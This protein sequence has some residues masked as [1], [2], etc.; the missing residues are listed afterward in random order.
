MPSVRGDIEHRRLN[1]MHSQILRRP[2][3]PIDSPLIFASTSLITRN[4]TVQLVR[5]RHDKGSNNDCSLLI[6]ERLMLPSVC[7]LEVTVGENP[8]PEWL[9]HR[10]T[11]DRARGARV[12][13]GTI[14]KL[15]PRGRFF[16]HLAWLSGGLFVGQIL[17]LAVT[18]LLSRLYS[19]ADFGAFAV[20]AALNGIFGL[21]MAGRYEYAIPLA[22]EENE[23]GAL[24]ALSTIFTALLALLSCLLVWMFAK[25][26]AELVGV[27]QLAPYF[28]L[29]PPLLLATGLG[30]PLDYWFMSRGR[31]K[32]CGVSRAVQFGGQGVSQVV[33]GVFGTG[34]FGLTVGYLL[35]YVWR[36]AIFVFALPRA[37]LGLIT[38]ARLRHVGR[39][40]WS[41]KRYPIY[42]ATSSVLRSTTQ[43]LPTILL[44]MLYGTAVAGGFDMAQRILTAPVRLLSNAASQVF[45][46]EASQLSPA[47]VLRLFGRTVPRFLLVGVIGMA[48][49][50]VAGPAIFALVFGEPWR[51]AGV[52]AQALVA[53]QLVRFVEAPVS[54]AFNVFGRQDLEFR[55][56][57]LTAVA[58]ITSFSLIVVLQLKAAAA[59]LVYSLTSALSHLAILFFA[60]RTTR[61]AAKP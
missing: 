2:R 37:D 14:A 9:Q 21:V 47:G 7:D 36:L 46:T 61:L 27:P 28:W 26:I 6:D 57:L 39:L 12:L 53:V 13:K 48:P 11:A 60:W 52:F 10:D 33:L 45:L 23:V 44:A 24:I 49:V 5:N 20:I 50:L 17:L 41:L 30:Q 43:F 40:A 3:L 51:E 34:A 58:L 32:L 55:S 38:A 59:V 35:G 1:V 8:V 18:P 16:R 15:F 42:A 22:R 4:R 56:T 19:P 29:V 31:T 54:Q 25:T